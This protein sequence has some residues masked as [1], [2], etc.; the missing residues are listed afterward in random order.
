MKRTFAPNWYHLIGI[1]AHMDAV[2][3]ANNEMCMWI[4]L[5]G[6]QRSAHYV[7]VYDGITSLTVIVMYH[8]QR[9]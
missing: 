4:V 9:I 1:D 8:Y 5:V 2:S 7:Y 3:T 6:R